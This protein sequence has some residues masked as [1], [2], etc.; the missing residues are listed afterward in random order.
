MIQIKVRIKGSLIKKPIGQTQFN[1]DCAE[2]TTVAGLLKNF[3]YTDDQVRY[4]TVTVNYDVK[5]HTYVL[6]NGDEVIF[7]AMV[8]GG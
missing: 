7:M 3:D 8:G 6:Q 1:Y 2:G 4:I 5:P